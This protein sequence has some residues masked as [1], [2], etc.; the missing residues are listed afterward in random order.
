[1]FKDSKDMLLEACMHAMNQDETK[2]RIWFMQS[3]NPKCLEKYIEFLPENT[4]LLTTL[5]TNRD[6]GYGEI[7]KAP[8]PSQ[9]YNDFLG[10]EWNKKMVTVEPILDFDLDTF[11]D[12]IVSI[13]PKA[14]FIGY[15]SHPNKVPLPEPEK[16]KT[17]QLIHILE[18]CRIQVLKKEMRDKRVRKRAH[19]DFEE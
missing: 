4:Y 19:R 5:E 10:L 8:K 9:R 15:N 12:W 7:S 11:V 13:S 14:V 18:E 6:I 16:K 2:D 17:W 3:K 1:M